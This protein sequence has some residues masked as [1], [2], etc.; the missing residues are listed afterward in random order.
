[1]TD[2]L[3][4]TQ[5]S[6][7]MRKVAAVP[8]TAEGLVNWLWNDPDGL[9]EFG[10]PLVEKKCVRT[11]VRLTFADEQFVVKRYVE[12]S[13]RHLLKQ[14]IQPSRAKRCWDDTLRL[15][16]AGFPTP[17]PIAY[18]EDRFGPFRGRS[19]YVYEYQ[20]G[21]TLL[22]CCR[23]LTNQRLL[24]NYVIQIVSI[25]QLQRELRVS[26]HDA[27]P[28]NFIIDRSGKIWVI[29]LDKLRHE[30]RD[31][32]LDERLRKSLQ[33]LLQG[34]FGD[35]AIIRFGTRKFEEMMSRVDS[36]RIAA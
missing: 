15:S 17:A 5:K 23:H 16:N 29:D 14:M 11:T 21:Q 3:T 32:R 7:W 34:V 30:T 27:N 13:F 35:Q 12:R 20:A 33:F 8:Y 22:E 26:L 28:G 36:G 2:H 10:K 25:W 4:L 19:F 6:T 24:R 18:R 31:E 9:L 1:M